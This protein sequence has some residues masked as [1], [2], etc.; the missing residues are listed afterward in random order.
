[1]HLLRGAIQHYDWGDEE[2]IPGLI[3]REPDGRPWAE[4]WFGTHPA[5][6]ALAIDDDGERP[7]AEVTGELPMMVKVLA[8]ARPLSL[9]THPTR[10]Q[11]RSGYDRENEAG[12]ALDDPGRTYRDRS[13]KPEVLVALTPFEALCG[14][15]PVRRSIALL[16]DV[17]MT[18]EARTLENEGLAGYMFG[19]LT[20]RSVP[21]IEREKCPGWLAR[22]ADLY[23]TDP[24]LRVAPLLNHVVLEPG[25]AVSLPAGNLHMYL[26]GAGLE[27][28]SASDNV[29][30]AGFTS[31]HV[32]IAELVRIVDVEELADPTVRPVARDGRWD[33]RCPTTAFSLERIDLDG[34][35]LLGSDPRPRLVVVT[36][37]DAGVLSRGSAAAI[38]RHESV[39][40]SGSATVW[41]CAGPLI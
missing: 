31:K 10:E 21:V 9:Q 13:D 35:H 28:M 39:T 36:D 19:A 32:D 33:Y 41:V 15:A 1:M 5:G 18:H 40:L 26:S 30:R 22:L 4:M 6:H 14:F 20:R 12:I 27:V 23:P 7:L 37:G 38:G 24:A 2:F 16:D 34:D 3:G 25:E 11:A 8:A 17:G 29:V